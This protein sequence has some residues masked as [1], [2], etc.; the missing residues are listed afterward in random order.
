MRQ[1][2]ACVLTPMCKFY[3][4]MLL[5]SYLV[6][7]R[8]GAGAEVGTKSVGHVPGVVPR[9]HALIAPTVDHIGC[10]DAPHGILQLSCTQHHTYA[11]I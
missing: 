11:T 10:Q 6:E 5:Q 7:G 2:K 8:L 9:S 1:R 3:A 4:R